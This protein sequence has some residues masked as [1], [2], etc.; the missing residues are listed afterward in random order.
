MIDGAC[1]KY[2]TYDASIVKSIV[3]SRNLFRMA[4]NG[5]ERRTAQQAKDCH[6]QE[7]CECS[8]IKPYAGWI[9]CYMVIICS[10]QKAQKQDSG[11]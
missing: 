9:L 2:L 8:S 6:D 7:D 10:D 5:M 4:G 3:L 1:Q 11:P